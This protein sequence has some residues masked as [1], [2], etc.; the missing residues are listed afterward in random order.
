MVQLACKTKPVEMAVAKKILVI[1]DDP[2]FVRLVEQV[3]TQEGYEVLTAVSGREGLRLLFLHRPDM[4]LLD[5]VMP[6]MDGWQTCSRIRD[7][8]DIPII[9]L[10]AHKKTEEDIVRGLDFGADNYIIKP[11]GRREL[12]G[13]VRAIMRR[14]E[15]PPQE[16]GSGITY[17]DGY[18]TVDIAQ[19]KVLVNGELVRLTPIEFRLLAL[20]LQNA[21][22]IL[23]HRQLLEKVW[24]WEYI[25]DLDYVRIYIW[26]LRQKI[27]PDQAQ[28][29]YIITELGVGY[30]FHKA[31]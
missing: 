18:L 28:P 26:H 17:S 12:V 16:A 4:V 23:T 3:L 25:D 29:K 24:G 20:L 2:A 15:L 5:V 6:E 14:A 19:R 22:R 7:I 8:S 10:T 9:M 1:D 11:V 30:S 27:E 31:K 21:G 13:R